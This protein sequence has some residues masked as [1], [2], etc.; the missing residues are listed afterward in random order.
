MKNSFDKLS[1]N[2]LVAKR[3]ELRKSYLNMRME[4]VLGHVE[5]PRQVRNARRQI[6]RLNTIIH[7]YTLGIRKAK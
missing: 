1:Y 7:E 6:A 5:N 3:D 4:K 2:E